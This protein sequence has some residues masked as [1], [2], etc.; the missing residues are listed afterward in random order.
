MWYSEFIKSPSTGTCSRAGRRLPALSGKMMTPAGKCRIA[1]KNPPAAA[2]RL[3][4]AN[5]LVASPA[6]RFPLGF[7][8]QTPNRAAARWA[9]SG[10]FQTGQLPA[11]F[12][13]KAPFTRLSLTIL[14]L[15]LLLLF[16][17]SNNSCFCP[18]PTVSA[19]PVLHLFPL[20]Q[21]FQHPLL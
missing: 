4:L 13:P 14:R 8:H 12:P 2:R 20:F 18:L 7:S 21:K 19:I 5:H 15:F 9:S 1:G 16:S 17:H 3:A 6:R 11:G 10:S